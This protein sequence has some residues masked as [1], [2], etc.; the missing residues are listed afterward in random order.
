MGEG[1]F[2]VKGLRRWMRVVGLFYLLL[3]VVGAII[4]LPVEQTLGQAGIVLDQTNLAHRFLVDTWV[5]FALEL[6]VI[7][8][9]LWF[10][11][12]HPYENRALIWT[13][14]GLELIR[15]IVDDIYMLIRGYD[16]AF[17]IGWI[18]IHSIIILTGLLALRS[19]SEEAHPAPTPDIPAQASS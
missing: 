2:L 16:P 6:G 4:K 11:S 12:G 15:G 9:A 19:A 10:F 14:L 7:G 17:Y 8:A 1:R 18:V 13:V 5:M 3:F